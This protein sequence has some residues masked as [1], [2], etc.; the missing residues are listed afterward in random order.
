MSEMYA[1]LSPQTRTRVVSLNDEDRKRMAD[2]PF[3]IDYTVATTILGELE[4]MLKNSGNKRATGYLIT[5]EARNGKTSIMQRFE[6]RHPAIVRDDDSSVEMPVVFVQ[7]PPVPDESRFYD[8]IL[9]R[10]NAPYKDSQKVSRKEYQI[11]YLCERLRVKA[12][13]VDEINNLVDGTPLK[14]RQLLNALKNMT[15]ELGIPIAVSGVRRILLALQTDPQLS[16]R[17]EPLEIPLWKC[18]DDFRRLLGA[19]EQRLPLKYLSPL[20]TELDQKIHQM[21]DGIIGEVA[22]LL[23]RAAARAIDTGTERITVDI[24]DSIR[25]TRPFVRNQANP[26][27]TGELK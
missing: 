18:D 21:S 20:S 23:S 4:E 16:K 22:R 27:L 12:L 19:F 6:S 1:H 5:G 2:K 8:K 14:Q 24:L 10:F 11:R 9:Q 25:W 13:L 7:A 26:S 17:F 3:W 15:N